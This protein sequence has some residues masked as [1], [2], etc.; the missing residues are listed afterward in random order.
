LKN[1][2]KNNYKII[3]RLQMNYLSDIIIKK[4][5]IKGA[6]CQIGARKKRGT[7][8]TLTLGLGAQTLCVAKA[9]TVLT[10]GK[11]LALKSV[12]KELNKN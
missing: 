11:V 4:I 6:S 7:G 12:L 9:Q 5:F 8:T 3:I 2:S 1:F 10:S